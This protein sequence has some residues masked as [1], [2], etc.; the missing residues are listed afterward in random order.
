V[1]V[2]LED[3]WGEREPQNRP[4]TGVDGGNWRRR[5]ALTLAEARRDKGNAEFLRTLNRARQARPEPEASAA[6]LVEALR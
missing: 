5:A 1:L 6:G 2:D 4:G 3:L